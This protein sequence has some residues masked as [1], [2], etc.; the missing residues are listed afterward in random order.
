MRG[1][2]QAIALNSQL[3]PTHS[4]CPVHA[5]MCCRIKSQ[6]WRCKCFCNFDGYCLTACP[7]TDCTVHLQQ[8]IKSLS[9]FSLK[10]RACYL[11]Y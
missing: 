4:R 6:P 3:K 10:Y 11:S 7:E 8:S 2:F 5:E 1:V 9:Y